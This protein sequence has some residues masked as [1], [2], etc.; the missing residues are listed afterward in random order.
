MRL[1]PPPIICEWCGWWVGIE[2]GYG[3]GHNSF[4]TVNNF[5]TVFGAPDLGVLFNPLGSPVIFNPPFVTTAALGSIHQ[6]GWLA[7]GF[8]GTQKQLSGTSWVIGL[9]A[10][11]DGADIHHSAAATAT[12]FGESVTS[13]SIGPAAVTVAGS[14]TAFV[15]ADT[16]TVFGQTI[17]S[18]G[19]FAPSGSIS[20][21]PSTLTVGP[22]TLSVTGQT[23]S[24][25]PQ[26]LSV[27]AETLS[28]GPQTLTVAPTFSGSLSTVTILVKET[29]TISPTSTP[30]LLPVTS[31][32]TMSVTASVSVHT[33]T[34]TGTILPSGSITPVTLSVSGQQLTVSAQQLTVSGQS[35]TVSAQQ[36]TVTQ[37]V[38]TIT[39]TGT[40]KGG[41]L[42]TIS[43]TGATNAQTV[44][45]PPQFAS[46]TVTAGGSTT[47]NVI[48]AT[49]VSVD[50]KRSVAMDTKIDELGSVRGRIGYT[51][52]TNWL[53][54][55]TGGLAWAHST[56]RLTLTQTLFEAGT[57][58]VLSSS[59]F[60][61][62]S[63]STLLGWTV[64]AGVD[65]KLTPNIILGAEYLHYDFPK[66]TL[67]F[68]DNA[69]AIQFGNAHHTVD[70]IKGRIS[71]FIPLFP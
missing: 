65:Y 42:A 51:P 26:T 47:G 6:N 7:G 46:V 17:T 45:I 67:A 39:P 50:V 29:F 37:Q 16:F 35:L 15:A 56:N 4:D 22:Q 10:D 36:L 52:F 70:A 44:T 33:L 2:A 61:A 48:N 64:G 28:I 57:T 59:V 9:E 41:T 34:G 32:V 12:S 27:T 71:W 69:I 8:F 58:N 20:F 66:N 11:I 38:L 25:G 43:V 49:P 18:T 21:A 24:I 63:S 31:T 60:N 1:P 23:L 53:F 62:T 30:D 5:G 68:S 55:G 54:Y 40:F 19:T 13:L 3:W 14:G